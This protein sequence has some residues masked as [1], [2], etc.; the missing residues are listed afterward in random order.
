MIYGATFAGVD[1]L[2]KYTTAQICGI[3][4]PWAKRNMKAQVLRA[5]QPFSFGR[6]IHKFSIGSQL[7][8]HS[9]IHFSNGVPYNASEH[10]VLFDVSV[11]YRT[12]GLSSHVSLRSLICVLQFDRYY[13]YSCV[14]YYPYDF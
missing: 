5:D 6:M 7:D 12:T 11:S 4:S 8:A 1:P 3:V 14:S 13:C 2:L 9:G 10:L